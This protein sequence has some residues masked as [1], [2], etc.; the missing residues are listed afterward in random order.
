MFNFLNQNKMKKIFAFAIAAATMAVGC[1]KIQSLV[2]PNDNQPVGEEELVEIK[3]SSNVVAVETK[4]G[5]LDEVAQVNVY[6]LNEAT[7]TNKR[8]V[9]DVPATVS[10]T[11]EPFTLTLTESAFYH[12]SA[13]YSFYG[14]YLDGATIT[15]DTKTD[16]ASALPIT[17]T[18]SNDVLLAA[19]DNNG[20]Y[21]AAAARL[22]TH[23]NLIFHHKLAKFTF[24]VANLGTSTLSLEDIVVVTPLRGNITLTGTQTLTVDDT[25]DAQ[26][27]DLTVS[28][29]EL[30]AQPAATVTDPTFETVIGA[31]ALVFPNS[32]YTIK[33]KLS[34]TSKGGTLDERTIPV[35]V[36][37]AI[38]P[39]YAYNFEV[40]LYSLE[41]IQITA[42][43]INWEPDTIEVDTENMEEE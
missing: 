33:F 29:M 38:Q 27:V 43:L 2:N 34:Q 41:E 16:Y 39:G 1:Q 42:T 35:T 37:E 36:T 28:Q 25:A 22:G 23:P 20:N 10:G 19:G 24:T 12:S 13:T 7:S 5:S 8:E 15:G 26:D 21:S 40:K 14:Y 4:V 18:G 3:F 32:K 30:D 17:I 6:G 31:E 9:I 11:E